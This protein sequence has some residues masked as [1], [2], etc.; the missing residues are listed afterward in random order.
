MTGKKLT[1]E[2]MQS[3]LL[4]IMRNTEKKQ[5]ASDKFLKF[6]KEKIL[7][8]C[9]FK[10]TT[11]PSK[12]APYLLNLD[13]KKYLSMCNLG[14]KHH[15]YGKILSENG[16]KFTLSRFPTPKAGSYFFYRF[17]KLAY[18]FAVS[19]RD[20]I[21]SNYSIELYY[22]GKDVIPYAKEFV[23]EY[24]KPVNTI[25]FYSHNYDNKDFDLNNEIRSD[26]SKYLIID[27][28]IEND[29]FDY[30]RKSLKLGERL[31]RDF[32]IIKNPGIIL[33]GEPGT[34]KSS[35]IKTLAYKFKADVYYC[36]PRNMDRITCDLKN[37]KTSEK[38]PVH[39]WII[40]FEDIDIIYGKRDKEM[41]EWEKENL[42]L[43][44]QFLDG[45]ASF[46]GCIKVAT[47]NHI[48]NLDDALIRPGRFDI[49]LEMGKIG[50]DDAKKMCDNFNVGYDI[51]EEKEFPINPSK[52]QAEIIQKL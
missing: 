7:E 39:P 16:I 49:K 37:I 5:N 19:K 30:V 41:E 38:W 51:L 29:T 10:I 34:G 26:P 44:L 21:L 11:Y 52:L 35:F 32:S 33:Y 3:M 15:I 36:S 8:K 43:L 42:N 27:D 31:F 4:G 17:D 24:L 22:F 12:A 45:A 18:L 13:T 28:G 50:K 46:P 25:R 20:S 1:N 6:L 9:A 14:Q 2:D 40:A 47:T 48:E 23:D